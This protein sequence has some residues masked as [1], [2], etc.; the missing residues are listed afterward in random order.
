M[1]EFVSQAAIK[2]GEGLDTF[3]RAYI[4]AIYFTETEGRSSEYKMTER[5]RKLVI[6]DCERFQE[7]NR[8][9]L[10]PLSNEEIEHAGHDFW[11]TRNGHGSGFWDGGW[12]EPEASVFTNYSEEVGQFDVYIS[13]RLI[14]C[15]DW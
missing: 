9:L 12:M 8:E 14:R 4:M 13:G 6:R 2:A 5:M 3:T 15:N 7:A 11:F 1:P 10:G